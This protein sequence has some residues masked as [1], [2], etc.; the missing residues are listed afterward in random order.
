MENWHNLPFHTQTWLPGTTYHIQ[1]ESPAHTC[2]EKKH[3]ITYLKKV[4]DYKVCVCRLAALASSQPQPRR[5]LRQ[6]KP[7]FP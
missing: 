1:L 5:Q 6:Q 3:K 4:K 7:L 2:F